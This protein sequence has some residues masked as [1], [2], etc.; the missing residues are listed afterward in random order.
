MTIQE[1]VKRIKKE[2]TQKASI[3]P[4]PNSDKCKIILRL[5]QG[6][7]TLKSGLTRRMAEDILS[8]AT[9]RLLLG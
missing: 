9:N 2:G 6:N 8:Q 1:I 3:E 4:I 5:P 7:V